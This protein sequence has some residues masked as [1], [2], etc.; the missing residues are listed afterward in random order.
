MLSFS[1]DGGVSVYS[2]AI[3]GVWVAVVDVVVVVG[4]A[5]S[6]TICATKARIIKE[7]KESM[8]GADSALTS[9]T[10]FWGCWGSRIG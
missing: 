9:F 6:L 7:S 3:D 4:G 10:K 5:S 2:V 1:E 8:N